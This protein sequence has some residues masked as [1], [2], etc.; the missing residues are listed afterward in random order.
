MELVILLIVA[1]IGVAAYRLVAGFFDDGKSLII[2]GQSE[3]QKPQYETYEEEVEVP[4]YVKNVSIFM[5]S[6]EVFEYTAECRNESRGGQISAVTGVYPIH[7]YQHPILY[8]DITL[9]EAM[10]HNPEYIYYPN[11]PRMDN[12]TVRFSID[13]MLTEVHS[14]DVEQIN[15][16]IEQVGTRKVINKLVRKIGT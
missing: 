7:C 3:I 4:T 13:G 1:F 2:Q 12:K 15:V 11:I 9:P 6:G 5:K 10:P 16:E 14:S 8:I